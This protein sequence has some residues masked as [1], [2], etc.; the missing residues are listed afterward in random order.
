LLALKARGLPISGLTIYTAASDP[1]GLLGRAGG[2]TSKAAWIDG[3]ALAAI[4]R[5]DGVTVATEDR[6][7][8]LGSSVPGGVIEVYPTAGQ[9][10]AC[11][12]YLQRL[13][14]TPVGDGYDEAV[15]AVLLR[16]SPYLTQAQASA[17]VRDLARCARRLQ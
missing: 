15:G 13:V 12:V 8:P 16:L 2:Y 4:A 3:R 7:I 10:R 1:S 9:A 5:R 11:Q 6:R 14:G 17:Y